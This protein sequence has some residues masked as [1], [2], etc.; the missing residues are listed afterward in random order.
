M[1]VCILVTYEQIILANFTPSIPTRRF[2]FVGVVGRLILVEIRIYT[3]LYISL[4]FAGICLCAVPY[5]LFPTIKN[6]DAWEGARRNGKK[7]AAFAT[8]RLPRVQK[9]IIIIVGRNSTQLLQLRQ[10]AHKTIETC[11]T[12]TLDHKFCR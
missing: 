11:A 1:N 9:G 10:S 8:M 12:A 3:H 2:E 6:K 4:T 7:K 5:E